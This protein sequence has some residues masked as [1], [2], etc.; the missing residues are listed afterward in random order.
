MDDFIT[1]KALSYANNKIATDTYGNV[2]LQWTT[3]FPKHS[4][5]TTK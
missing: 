3:R 4:F 2:L 1:S 5:I